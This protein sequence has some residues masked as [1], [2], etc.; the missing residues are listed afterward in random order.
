MNLTDAERETIIN[1]NSKDN[2]A[3]VHTRI[4]KHFRHFQKLGVK[5]VK[6]YKDTDNKEYAWD[7]EV[8]INWV[9]MPKS[10]KTLMLSDEQRAKIR[11][12]LT[13]GKRV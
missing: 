2:V 4:P 3:Y 10:P 8:P 13:Q 12:R 11:E 5:P 9:R 1:L 6:V 7:F